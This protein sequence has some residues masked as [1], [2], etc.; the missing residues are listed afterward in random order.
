MT[1]VKDLIARLRE[2][3]D[4]D[5]T[6]DAASARFYFRQAASALQSLVDRNEKLE[7]AL[8]SVLA[9]EIIYNGNYIEALEPSGM[10]PELVAKIRTALER[11][12]SPSQAQAAIEQNKNKNKAEGK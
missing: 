1:D 10:Y 9:A 11:T 4:P 5:A 3:D 2:L 6:M 7:E 8:R 12:G